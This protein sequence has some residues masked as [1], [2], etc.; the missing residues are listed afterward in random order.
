MRPNLTPNRCTTRFA[1]P[2]GSVARVL[3]SSIVP[4]SIIRI[5]R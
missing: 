4:I 2:P 3:A 1:L 5:R